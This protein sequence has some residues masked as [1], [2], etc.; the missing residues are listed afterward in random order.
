[1]NFLIG[2]QMMI[3]LEHVVLVERSEAGV[4]LTMV[5]DGREIMI[6]PTA[7]TPVDAIWKRIEEAL[8][9]KNRGH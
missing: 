9:A 3:N 6:E 5:A 2:N 1:M 7:T 8:T 4:V